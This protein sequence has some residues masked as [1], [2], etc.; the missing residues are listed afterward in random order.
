MPIL[1]SGQYLISGKVLD[2]K[3]E[4]VEFAAV[5]IYAV[6][7][8]NVVLNGTIAGSKGDFEL[9]INQLGEYRLLIQMIG[10]KDWE[11]LIVVDSTTELGMITLE[12]EVTNLQTVELI[13]ERS[14]LESRL[15]KK[16]LRI[17]Q[18]LSA[19]GSNALEALQSLP[20][21]T[22]TSRG[23]VQVRG[24]SKVIIYINGKET[25]RDPKSLKYIAAESLE[26]IELITNPSAKY[27]A[28]GVAGIINLVFK[29]EKTSKLKL[30]TISGIALPW[31]FSGGLNANWNRERFSCFANLSA[32]YDQYQEEYRSFRTNSVDSL[33]FYENRVNDQGSGWN[34]NL[35]IGL[36]YEKDST[37]SLSMG[38]NYSIW[39]FVDQTK[40]SS[41][42][43]FLDASSVLFEV[44]NESKELEHEW[45]WNGAFQK[46]FKSKQQLQISAVIGGENEDNAF[47]SDEL[48]SPSETEEF[49]QF[50]LR[51]STTERQRYYQAKA[52]FE[53]PFFKWGTWEIGTKLDI[54][55]YQIAQEIQLR[56]DVIILPDNDFEIDLQKFGA[57]F[58]QKH[59][60]KRFE[61]A[62]G[63]RGER[64]NSEAAQGANESRFTQGLFR[65]FPSVQFNYL[66]P[67]L[68]HTIGISFSQ[69][70]NRPGFFDLN[71]YVSYSDPFN[72]ETGNPELSPEIA[73]LFEGSYHKVFDNLSLDFTF[74]RRVTEEVIQPIVEAIDNDQFLEKPINIDRQIDHGLEGQ[75]AYNWKQ[76][77]NTTL[78]FV[79]NKIEF[80]DPILE[81]QDNL[82]SNWST[83]LQ[84][85]LNWPKKW[86]IESSFTYRSARQD[87][88]RNIQAIYY[89]NLYARKKLV[90]QRGSL[91]IGIRDVFNT[92]KEVYRFQN[93]DFD[94]KRSLKWQ[95]RRLTIAW[96]Y[97]L[98]K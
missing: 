17:G 62:I 78:S 44:E 43:D 79:W 61:Y 48:D 93:P 11:R 89:V 26:R 94:L 30:E 40:Q 20:S 16:V 83:R 10:Y 84:I 70:M 50:L 5:A 14:T 71:P 55:N 74:F 33:K 60:V 7:D 19:S 65:L 32:A 85:A 13:A 90:N 72:L 6:A 73:N 29:K 4:G 75:L 59:R 1:C 63:V 67:D 88:Q 3:G 35:N 46:Q 64:F 37:Q 66:L 47:S 9:W 41:Q 15:G 92:Q 21:V 24:S 8:S 49:Q 18:D 86:R 34:T 12:E 28:E 56:S 95:T 98:L 52:D 39:D 22:A 51:S 42:F 57:Y 45:W 80:D 76:K 38:F 2:A 82:S 27:D 96:R 53:A 91:T 25:R 77:I 81:D 69:R 97:V 36:E 68:S 87:A 54:I 31:R 23:Q 58:L